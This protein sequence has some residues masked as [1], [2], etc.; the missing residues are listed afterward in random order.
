MGDQPC[1]TMPETGKLL[2]IGICVLSG[3][4]VGLVMPILHWTGNYEFGTTQACYCPED[5]SDGERR[6]LRYEELQPHNILHSRSGRA[7]L[8]TR[9]EDYICE[10]GS[11]PSCAAKITPDDNAIICFVL[12]GLVPSLGFCCFCCGAFPE[13]RTE[14]LDC[15]E[16]ACKVAY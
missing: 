5:Q 7:L 11:K 3:S 16:V 9:D 2:C 1:S 14:L 4:V 8:G 10:D 6:S 15:S 13:V 12:A